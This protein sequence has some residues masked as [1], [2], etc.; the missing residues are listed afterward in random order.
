MPKKAEK[1]LAFLPTEHAFVPKHEIV[2]EKEKAEII[3]KFNASPAQFPQILVSDPVVRE[4][5]GKPGDLIKVTRE[6]QTAD[7]FVFYRFV[8]VD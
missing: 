4:I 1:K 6:S 3:K 7:E 5:G 2:E 8:V